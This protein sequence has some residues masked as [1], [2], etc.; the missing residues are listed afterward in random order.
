MSD[1]LTQADVQNYGSELLEV[2]QRAAL[3]AIAP[4]LM[5]LEQQNAEL[6]RRLAKEARHR[7][8]QQVAAAVPNYQEIDRDPRWHQFLREIDTYTGQPRQALLNIAIADGS[9]S[10]VVALFNGFLREAGGTQSTPA[11]GHRSSGKPIYTRETIGQL[12]E[13][14]RKGAYTGREQE[15]ARQEADI[16]AAQREGRVQGTPYLTK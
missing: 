11:R 2:S 13:A 3:H 14:H 15:W 9:A 6:Q 5:S 4:H 10:R 7:L 8:D 1:Y 12:Y 16:F